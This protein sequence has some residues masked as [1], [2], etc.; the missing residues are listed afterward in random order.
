MRSTLLL[1]LA[2]WVGGDIYGF[3]YLFSTPFPVVHLC[4]FIEITNYCKMVLW[5]PRK[6][7]SDLMVYRTRKQTFSATLFLFVLIMFTPLC[8]RQDHLV[9]H[10]EPLFLHGERFEVEVYDGFPTAEEFYKRFVNTAKPVI[11]RGGAMLFSAS[12]LWNDEYFL[13]FP[14]SEEHL[15]T[16]EVEKKENRS[17]P[18]EDIPSADFVRGLYSSGKYMVSSVPEFLRYLQHSNYRDI[19]TDYITH[20]Q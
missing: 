6:L 15:V 11:F 7:A 14:E 18:G 4:T 20:G 16:V 9:G 10:L 8:A 5:A 3:I 19:I 12:S 13:S 17:T 2:A 1:T